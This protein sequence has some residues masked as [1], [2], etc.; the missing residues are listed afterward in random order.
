MVWAKRFGSR[1]AYVVTSPRNGILLQGYEHADDQRIQG[2][3][4]DSGVDEGRTGERAVRQQW[5]PPAGFPQLPAGRTAERPQ[6]TDAMI[7]AGRL[8]AGD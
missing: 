8:P 1:G 5:T 2:R 6:A 4:A 3:T 7:S